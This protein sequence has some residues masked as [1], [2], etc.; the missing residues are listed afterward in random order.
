MKPSRLITALGGV[1]SVV[2][3]WMPWYTGAGGSVNGFEGGTNDVPLYL[4]P[5]ILGAVA[6]A[7]GMIGRTWSYIIALLAGLGI[8]GWA[9]L[10]MSK[11][12][13]EGATI[14]TGVWMMF[15]AFGLV[16]IGSIMGFAKK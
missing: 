7:F 6:L 2:S 4:F 8:L 16:L 9:M 14:G 15:A 1:L 11:G 5:I 10:L 3:A 12:K 13:E